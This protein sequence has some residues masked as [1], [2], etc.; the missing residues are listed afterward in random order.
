MEVVDEV[1]RIVP[2]AAVAVGSRNAA[3]SVARTVVVP[4]VVDA[5]SDSRSYH[6]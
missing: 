1:L 3:A 6:W 5:A 2:A 4:L